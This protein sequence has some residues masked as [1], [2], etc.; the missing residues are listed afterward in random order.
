MK[1]KLSRRKF[2][3]TSALASLGFILPTHLRLSNARAATRVASRLPQESPLLDIAG[4]FAS[5]TFNGDDISHPHDVLWDRENYIRK[6][7][8][9]PSTFTTEKV[10]VIGGG[11]SGLLTAHLLRDLGPV[12][13]EQAPSFG[14][15]SKGERYKNSAFSIGAA[16]LTVP[17]KEGDIDHLFRDLG[18]ANSF[19]K[20]PESDALVLMK[21]AGL[22]NLWK[23]ETDP[24][25]KE[26]AQEVEKEL[27][28][29]YK[30]AYPTI[31]WTSASSLSWS[32]FQTLDR[33]NAQNW[34]KRMF[35]K[36]HPH[37]EEYFQTYA[38]S[39]FGGSLGE[40]SAAQ[41]LNFV[42]A[43]TD[44][45]IAFPGGNSAIGDALHQSLSKTLPSAGLRS[46]SIVIEV[47][48]SSDGVE[49]L[50]EDNEG[51]LRLLQAKAAVV[52]AP[53]YVARYI[54]EGLAPDRVA[55]WKALHYRAYVVANILLKQ[56]APAPGFDVFCL[57]GRLPP[58]P[59]FKNPSD[60]ACSDF[61]FA[62]WADH[63]R[64]AASV[65]TMY[66]PY[67]FE[68]ARSLLTSEAS[69]ARIREELER[70]LPATLSSLGIPGNAVDGIRL[71]RWG[72][73]IPLAQPGL[74]ASESFAQLR[75]PHGKIA[76]ANQDN[77]MNAGFET[78]FA[79]AKEAA[80]FVRS[81]LR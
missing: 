48:N 64:G 74:A 30:D 61:V 78:C 53:K 27:T 2:L 45:V 44:G 15:N 10:V 55:H 21:N 35:P 52:A 37:V 80:T 71:T 40:I 58:A 39:S 22:R 7:G 29:I 14:G 36:L 24:A 57:E 47:K 67:P 77:F 43:E 63:G 79:A 13:I 50:Y 72:H 19:R 38:W 56:A 17:E 62:G 65:L 59:T 32:E 66:K 49:I 6:K 33:E 4:T 75:L 41:F 60:R 25:A 18:L 51:K 3:Q 70:A 23:G 8:G 31:P 54:V 69:H 16:Y 11:M 34:L 12:L 76:F 28:R 68:G 46:R 5:G 42:S 9:R 81:A 1:K 20:E 26:S 73:S